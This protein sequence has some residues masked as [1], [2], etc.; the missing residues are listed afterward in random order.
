[1]Y[2]YVYVFLYLFILIFIHTHGYVYYIQHLPILC[3]SVYIYVA[4]YVNCEKFLLFYML[5]FEK[6]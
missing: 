6:F 1:M 4:K 3:V 5:Y 2:I